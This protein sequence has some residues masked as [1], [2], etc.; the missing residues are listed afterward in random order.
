[1]T[2]SNRR[3][4]GVF[5]LLLAALAAMIL[6]QA[7][8]VSEEEAA[9][10][11]VKVDSTWTRYD[12]V[13]VILA[14]A[15]GRPLD[16]LFDG[17]LTS[18]SQ[19]GKLEASVFDGGRVQVILIGYLDGEV[20]KRETRP[21]DGGTGE[22]GDKVVVVL[23]PLDPDDPGIPASLDLEPA[24]ATLY[25][26]GPALL[27]GPS[28][29]G[30]A[31]RALAWTSADPAVATVA[32]G[33]VVAVAPGMTWIKAVYGSLRDSTEITVVT[34]APVIDAGGDTVV[35]TNV[36]VV[37]QV[38]VRQETGGVADFRWSLDGDTLWDD[39]TDEVP[40]TATLLS[41]P[42]RIFT[43]A[44]RI[45]LRFQ[46]TDGEGN[47]AAAMR[48]V[49]VAGQAPRILS[50]AGGAEATVGDSITFSAMAEVEPGTLTKYA[51][52]FGDGSSADSGSLD[53]SRAEIEGGHRYRTAG[54]F[55]V[56]LTVEDDLGSTVS[57]NRTVQILPPRDPGVPDIAAL[58]PG[59]TTLSI[60]D[61]LTF[62]A[63]VT[64]APGLQ[65]YAWDFES[66]G[67]AEDSGS[68]SGTT[69]NLSS[70]RRFPNPGV[71][72][73]TLR[74][75][76]AGGGIAYRTARIT[77]L[78]DAPTANAGNDT[79]V[80][81]GSRVNL[82]GKAS[83]GLGRVSRTEWKIGSAA[84]V[85]ASPETSFTAPDA[86]GA[87]VCTFRV[88]DDDGLASTDQ[89]RITV[90]ASAASELASLTTTAGPL[91]PAFAPG[92]LAYTVNTSDTAATLTAAL[93]AGSPATLK[94]NGVA[95][96]SGAASAS[97]PIPAGRS[98]EVPVLVTA[99]DGSTRTYT[100]TFAVVAAGRPDLSFTA[101]SLT[102]K[103]SNRVNYS[104]TIRN[105]GT[106]AI[107]DIAP[108]SIQ[109]YWSA[110]TVFNNT[111]D[112]AG[113]GAILGVTKALGPGESH[114]GTFH[115]T[116]AIP[117]GMV[118]LTLKVDWGDTV[119]ESN[120]ANNTAYR[121]VL[122]APVAKA[123]ADTT[124]AAGSVARLH[125]TSSDAFGTV[126][127]TEWKIGAAAYVV[128]SPDTNF[129]AP[130]VGDTSIVCIFRV[131]D[132]DGLTHQ[133]SKTVTV[134]P[135]TDADLRALAPS[136][137]TL[138]PTFARATTAYALSVGN[139]V[140]SLT[141]TPTA[142]NAAAAI[143]VNGTAV[144]SGS[145]SVSLALAVGAN[146]VA[147]E[148]TAQSGLK[149][150]YTV[151]ATRAASSVNTL[152]ALTATAGTL[153]P[154][155]AAGTLTYAVSAS[156][157]TTRIT[158]T[159]TAGS[160]ATVRVNGV[161]VA[162][163]SA[164]AAISLPAGATT[165]IPIA[166]TAQN[167]SVRTYNIAFTVPGSGL[168]DLVI[169]SAAIT[170]VSATRIEYSYT[171]RNSGGATIPSLSSVSIQNFY[172]ANNVFND[173]GD[174]AAGGAILNVNKALAPGESHTGTFAASGAPGTSMN[175]LTWKIDW[176]DD[177][178][179]SNENN[180]TV[181]LPLP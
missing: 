149:K 4:R 89:V 56:T 36:P 139:S 51:W 115:A 137:G 15:E 128:A 32:A 57:A 113:G 23:I 73:V 68:L 5:H 2:S 74:V 119:K 138:S 9:F 131:T 29:S 171:I 86:G 71:F 146:T 69:A 147:V 179:E 132:D 175:Y 97:I 164:S 114:S 44:G 12:K 161:A 63:R 6:V 43:A 127:K 70:G 156:S 20:A 96:A 111:G 121:K 94:V 48:N 106:V 116:G 165:T 108:V 90:S 84:Y 21:F 28:G 25:T 80:A 104:Y 11:N 37:F 126:V 166:V 87:L 62:S 88:T 167:G 105:N 24:A 123:G 83:D 150:T 170:T 46:V 78:T 61:S 1:M 117:D 79:T 41:A 158:P 178:E 162:T 136:S 151:T 95:A 50:L 135:S 49:T 18:P 85:T 60:K 177:V 100:V 120:E 122:V 112:I 26:G 107:A 110:D 134:S 125:G 109:N 142:S 38:R 77:V 140:S 93:P 75:H 30:W 47:V 169:T 7:C 163:G 103:A 160:N 129:T 176:G 144:A 42:A 76:G 172:S 130:A 53:A 99:Q 92:I 133:D 124:V 39:S 168:A 101:V 82:R 91:V 157:T 173:A 55:T 65:A 66:D 174:V 59:D 152:Q 8:R 27:L 17:R 14:D 58:K 72:Q 153:S 159:V 148:V 34:D 13:Q 45:A 54:T 19:L 3:H 67:Q 40:A 81:A 35:Q 22:T 52:K 155:F 143:R 10:L 31:G 154:A 181:A 98:T 64:S 145:P 16:T 33:S 141:I 102:S 180:N 118:Y